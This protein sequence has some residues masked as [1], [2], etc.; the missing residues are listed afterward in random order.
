MF[1]VQLKIMP[2]KGILNPESSAVSNG[3]QAMGY[4]TVKGLEIGKIMEFTL[5]AADLAAAES[6]VKEMC[7]RLLANPVTEDY[8]YQITQSEGN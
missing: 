1:K 5:R 7:S 6:S 4:T 3:L 8:I 2:R